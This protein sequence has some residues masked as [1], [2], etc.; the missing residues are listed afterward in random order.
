MEAKGIRLQ[1]ERGISRQTIAQGMPACPGCTCRLVCA[2]TYTLHT[3]PRVQ[4][5]PGIPCSLRREGKGSCKPRTQTVSREGEVMFQMPPASLRAQRSNPWRNKK[6][7]MDCLAALAMTWI[8]RGIT[9]IPHAQSMT[10]LCVATHLRGEIT[11]RKEPTCRSAADQQ[12]FRRYRLRLRSWACI[13]RARICS[14]ATAIR[15]TAPW[16]ASRQCRSAR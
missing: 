12:Q 10:T 2:S 11:A 1:G 6:G 5:A 8:S 14:A 4:Q 15:D 3:R 7:R 16:R 9:D 13:S